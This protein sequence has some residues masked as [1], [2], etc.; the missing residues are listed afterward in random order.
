MISGGG[1]NSVNRWVITRVRNDGERVLA[2]PQQGRFTYATQAE[3]QARL[4]AITSNKHNSPDTLRQVFG[5]V[6]TMS[7]RCVPCYSGHFDP[8]SIYAP[9]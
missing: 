6:T 7:V 8:I 4:D 2:D 9:D 5:D 3:A 1:N